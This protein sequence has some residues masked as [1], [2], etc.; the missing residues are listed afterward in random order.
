MSS[1]LFKRENLFKPVFFLLTLICFA[2]PAIATTKVWN[3]LGGNA[4][5]STNGNWVGNVAP[6]AGDIVQ[7]GS[8]TTTT[9]NLGVAGIYQIHFTGSS[10]TINGAVTINGSV[11]VINILDDDDNNVINAAISMTGASCEIAAL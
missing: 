5:W 8:N 1:I 11:V 10:N 3:G 6:V 7:F 9:A 4:N 2:Q